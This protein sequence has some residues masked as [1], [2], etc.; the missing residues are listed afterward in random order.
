M[1]SGLILAGFVTSLEK[2]NE[3]V[4]ELVIDFIQEKPSIDILLKGHFM[5]LKG[6]FRKLCSGH[7]VSHGER[8][9]VLLLRL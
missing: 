6:C 3:W 9:E 7:A 4:G 5:I 1:C 8:Y 2:E